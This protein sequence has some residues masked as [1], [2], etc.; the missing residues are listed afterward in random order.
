MV[1]LDF[2][3]DLE[4]IETAFTD[5]TQIEQ[6]IPITDDAETEDGAKP[7]E[8]SNEMIARVIRHALTFLQL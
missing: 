2:S 5:S 8:F 6:F 1:E 4:Q 7:L 3:I